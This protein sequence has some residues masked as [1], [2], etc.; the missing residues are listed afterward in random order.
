MVPNFLTICTCHISIPV[1][2]PKRNYDNSGVTC[3]AGTGRGQ[4]VDSTQ[5]KGG[6]GKD[7]GVGWIL[8][9]IS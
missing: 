2:Q 4:K 9:I 8:P 5:D 3:V 7:D 6:G 1:L